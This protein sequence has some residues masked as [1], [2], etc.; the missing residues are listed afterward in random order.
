MDADLLS[1]PPGV[2]AAVTGLRTYEYPEIA[3]DGPGSCGGTETVGAR[4]GGAAELTDRAALT[5]PNLYTVVSAVT[6]GAGY[7]VLPRSLCED[8]LATGRLV[9]LHD[10]AEPPLNTLC[11]VQRPGADAN[12][13][14]IRVRDTLRRTARTW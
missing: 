3:D 5:V 7:S 2:P 13:D 10:P 1:G 11:L 14:V 12:P 6:A 8:H 4:H 9:L